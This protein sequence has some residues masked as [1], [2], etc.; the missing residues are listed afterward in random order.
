[1]HI[2]GTPH[3][4]YEYVHAS[5]GEKK[6]EYDKGYKIGH[7]A[8]LKEWRQTN[9]DPKVFKIVNQE[10]IG[11]FLLLQVQYPNCKNFEGSKILLYRNVSPLDLL[12]Q[13]ELDPHFSN[14]EKYIAPVARFIPT[15]EG[16][17]MAKMFAQYADKQQENK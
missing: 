6:A 9:P 10:V 17:L 7:E 14:K 15:G 5:E 13:G 12:V 11:K 4:R 8:A 2:P 16:W 1:M 3:T